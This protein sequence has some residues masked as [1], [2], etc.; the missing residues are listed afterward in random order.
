MDKRFVTPLVVAAGIFVLAGGYVHAREWWDVY[1]DVPSSVPGSWVVRI[2]FPVHAVVS[3]VVAGAL[4]VASRRL[5]LL[6]VA[7]AGALALQ[8]GSVA[9]LVASSEG[10]VL[11]W[12]EPGYS[13]AARQA[14]AVEAGAI[15]CL[16][17]V[18]LLRR[19]VLGGRRTFAVA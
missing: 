6:T 3:A 4:V 17:G 12:S 14:L 18:L 1:R 8:V 2:G 19:V 7:I 13:L 11:G 9:A 10:T 15:V 16:L 5:R